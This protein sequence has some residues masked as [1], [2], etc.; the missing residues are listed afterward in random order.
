MKKDEIPQDLS[1]L[2]KITKEVVYATDNTGKYTTE[3]SSGWDVKIEALNTA[4]SDIEKRV[5]A[6]KQKVW[7]S[8]ILIWR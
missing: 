7:L 6:A 4:W 3:L 1:A 5:A 8:P 2:G